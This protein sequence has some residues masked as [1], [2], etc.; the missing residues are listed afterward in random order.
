MTDA[1]ESTLNRVLWRDREETV[2]YLLAKQGWLPGRWRRRPKLS[3][4]KA[5]KKGAYTDSD[6]SQDAPEAPKKN[7][8]DKHRGD[9]RRSS[10]ERKLL[11][12]WP[13]EEPWPG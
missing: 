7:Q 13:T 5:Q 11:V 2:R 6:P 12:G 8:E 10:L 1:G 9:E 4:K 3:E